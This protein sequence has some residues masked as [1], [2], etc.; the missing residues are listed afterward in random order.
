MEVDVD[1]KKGP[2][3]SITGGK[4]G[5]GVEN[6]ETKDVIRTAGG[7]P[8]PCP[9]GLLE[10]WV[11][12]MVRGPQSDWKPIRIDQFGEFSLTQKCVLEALH[13]QQCFDGKKANEI[14]LSLVGGG[15]IERN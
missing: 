15:I 11:D 8:K 5:G 12:V 9:D 14:Q 4:G 1:A 10:S 6:E 2:V 13:D 7:S 3:T